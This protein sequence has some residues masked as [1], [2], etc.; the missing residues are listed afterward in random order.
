[1]SITIDYEA[2][3]G[4]DNLM[5]K[6]REFGKKNGVEVL[7]DNSSGKVKKGGL[8]PVE[9]TYSIIGDNITIEVTKI[10]FIASWDMA[11]SEMLKWLKQND[12]K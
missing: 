11:R 8:L 3:H 2:K 7:G 10:P 4:I 9:G 5:D 1:M 6:A 12:V